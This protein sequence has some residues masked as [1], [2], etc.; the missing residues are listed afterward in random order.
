VIY[1][2]CAPSLEPEWAT[3]YRNHYVPIKIVK[4][5]SEHQVRPVN[6]LV[7]ERIV[8]YLC[9][10]APGTTT[11]PHVPTGSPQASASPAPGSGTVVASA[12]PEIKPA[13]S[14]E[15]TGQVN[16]AQPAAGQTEKPGETRAKQWIWLTNESVYGYGYVDENGF[17]IVDPTTKTTTPTVAAAN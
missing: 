11:C 13:P 14:V 8:H 7:K 12:Q 10:C 3:I 17:A 16:P 15:V 5:P 4:K 9:D 6:I 1:D 2:E